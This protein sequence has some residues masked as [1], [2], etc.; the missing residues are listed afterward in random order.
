MLC[1]TCIDENVAVAGLFSPDIV[2][3]DTRVGNAPVAT[4][5][6]H[7]KS[8]LDITHPKPGSHMLYTTSE[9]RHLAAF[10][11]RAGQLRRR[12]HLNHVAPN[13]P[14]ALSLAANN[15]FCP[16]A[17]YAG[18]THGN[19]HLFDMRT[20][21]KLS[22]TSLWPAGKGSKVTGLAL[23]PAGLFACSEGGN[24]NIMNPSFPPTQVA[25]IASSTASL[26]GVNLKLFL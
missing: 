21:Q 22:S 4:H 14:Y 8:V 15:D 10:D 12:K 16:H 7:K 17:L 26:T 13:M 18:D 25:T 2:I 1:I 23:S 9:D 5:R 11:M 24:I 6:V 20:L 3:L 19:L